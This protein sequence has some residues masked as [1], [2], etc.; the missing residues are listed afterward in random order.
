MFLAFVKPI[1]FI[2]PTTLCYGIPEGLCSEI[3]TFA[4]GVFNN[5]SNTFVERHGVVAS[6]AGYL[7]RHTASSVI[8]L[9]I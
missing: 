5:N 7:C 2:L 8:V 1:Y 9:K 6:E 3:F 4:A